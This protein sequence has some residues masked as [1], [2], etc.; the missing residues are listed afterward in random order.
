MLSG[1]KTVQAVFEACPSLDVQITED[2]DHLLIPC[3]MNV[4]F[5]LLRTLLMFLK[6]SEYHISSITGI[7]HL[8]LNT[9]TCYM[10]IMRTR[11]FLHSVSFITCT[12]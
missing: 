6:L 8:P 2:Q 3:F 9:G 4:K 5:I 11:L 12:P 1:G 10:K 7:R